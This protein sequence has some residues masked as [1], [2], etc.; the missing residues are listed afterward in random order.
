MFSLLIMDRIYKLKLFLFLLIAPGG[1]LNSAAQSPTEFRV[2]G[3][4]SG[5]TIPVD[6]FETE[7]LTHLIFC[8]GNLRENRLCINSAADSST[9]KRMVELKNK[10]PELKVML[11][12][13]GWGGC[14]TCS[15]V[16]SSGKARMEFAQSV[17]EVSAFFQTDGIDLDWEYP[18]IKGFPG[19]TYKPEDRS[20]FSLL[21]KQLRETNGPSF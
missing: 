1:I 17:R 11:S 4:Y 7:K 2:V 19:H 16:F 6:S 20:N 12:L 18:A 8:F 5:T 3:Y 9:I 15:D 21:L 13:G 10:H 14:S